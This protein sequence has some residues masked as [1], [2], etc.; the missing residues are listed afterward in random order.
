[1]AT[2]E[3]GPEYAPLEPPDQFSVPDV[4]PLEEPPAAA[5]PAAAPAECPQFGDPTARVAPL[6]ALVPAA[7]EEPRDPRTPYTVESATVTG[8]GGS[9]WGAAHWHAPDGGTGSG[10]PPST[11]APA[12][13]PSHTAAAPSG[14]PPHPA[15]TAN[16][17]VASPPG[18]APAIGNF[19]A[20]GTPDWFGP[21]PA[22]AEPPPPPPSVWR[23]IPIGA[24]IALVCAV[25][26]LPAPFAF[27]AGFLLSLP[28]KYA[29]RA[30]MFAW[31]GVGGSILFIS[32]LSTLS[33]YGD[34]ADWYDVVQTWSL[35]GSVLMIILIF[36]I[37][38]HDIKYPQHGRPTTPTPGPQQPGTPPPGWNQAPPPPAQQP[39]P[40]PT[41]GNQPGGA[42]WPPPPPPTDPR[43]QQ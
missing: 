27:V 31:A 10:R 40:P 5:K 1:M 24:V 9:A 20:P 34:L 36:V 42:G 12:G 43:Q 35:L 41:P 17:P 2:W 15:D 26:Y 7:V 32:I 8:S 22:P 13:S 14:S 21:G 19:P 25:F 4:E 18:P 3:D 38:N 33:N 28:A 23:A 11:A 16:R 39:P 30:L 37:V 6:T 29:R